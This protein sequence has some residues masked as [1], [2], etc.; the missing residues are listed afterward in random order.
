MS[1]GKGRLVL[2]KAT[3]RP[4][5]LDN[6]DPFQVNHVRETSSCCWGRLGTDGEAMTEGGDWE[7]FKDVLVTTIV[8]AKLAMKMKLMLTLEGAELKIWLRVF[9]NP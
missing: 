2:S 7:T 3:I 6:F 9:P 1:L 5:N 8:G 4:I